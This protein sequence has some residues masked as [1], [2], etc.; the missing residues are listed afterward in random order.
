[1]P[2]FQGRRI[3]EF[4]QKLVIGTLRTKYINS[5][6]VKSTIHSYRCATL[7]D[8]FETVLQYRPKRLNTLTI[9]TGYN[10]NRLHPQELEQQW[11][12]LINLVTNKF[13]PKTL[14]IPKTIQNC[15]NSEVNRKIYIHNNV[16]FNLINRFVHSHTFNVS[17]NL[18]LN[19]TPQLFC[20]DGI[21]F[22]FYG[23]D[24]FTNFLANLIYKFSANLTPPYFLKWLLKHTALFVKTAC[25]AEVFGASHA[26]ATCM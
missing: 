8:L 15:K 4:S 6:L 2:Q 22:S 23:D 11:K 18:N 14:I 21:H 26:Q 7:R 9:V 19:L 25:E 24:F 3:P 5:A 20:C 12:T 13:Q 1:M 16:L 10:D 17:P